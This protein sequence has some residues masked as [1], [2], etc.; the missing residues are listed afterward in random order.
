MPNYGYYGVVVKIFAF[1]SNGSSSNLILVQ[2]CGA[3]VKM[4]RLRAVAV[5]LN[6]GSEVV[7]LRQFF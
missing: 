2:G 7:E 3:G 4:N 5:W 1:G 6:K